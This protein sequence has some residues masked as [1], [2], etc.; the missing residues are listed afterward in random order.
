MYVH[1]CL[2]S[3]MHEQMHNLPMQNILQTKPKYSPSLTPSL[4]SHTA[5]GGLLA[6]KEGSRRIH[7]LHHSAL[8]MGT[9]WLWGRL[10]GGG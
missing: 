7:T 1:V 9:R 6:E 4:T 3:L 2:Y 8:A 10:M 5:G